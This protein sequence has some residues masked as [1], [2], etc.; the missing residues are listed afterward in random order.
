[1]E[2]GVFFANTE[3]DLRI[4]QLQLQAGLQAKIRKLIKTVCAV[5]VHSSK[6]H[7]LSIVSLLHTC[8]KVAIPVQADEKFLDQFQGRVFG[9]DTGINIMFVE[10]IHILVKTA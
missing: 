1:M 6:Y 8:I 4:D 10:G 5:R 7:A 9:K 3:V 2:S